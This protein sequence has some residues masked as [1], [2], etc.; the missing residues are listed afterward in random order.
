MLVFRD[1]FIRIFAL[2]VCIFSLLLSLYL[3]F[4]SP[5][6]P[7][8]GEVSFAV[9]KGDK[10]GYDYTALYLIIANI[11]LISTLIFLLGK[12]KNKWLITILFVVALFSFLSHAYI[13][14]VVYCTSIMC[15]VGFIGFLIILPVVT[16]ISISTI[17][18]AEYLIKRLIEPSR[19]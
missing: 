16:I 15:G 6:N 14:N 8:L 1:M 11:T 9:I 10:S 13:V 4:S 12:T 2:G 3:F 17:F 7:S 18:G 19:D 5:H